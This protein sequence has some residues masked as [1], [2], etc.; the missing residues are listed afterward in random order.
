MRKYYISSGYFFKWERKCQCAYSRSRI[1]LK[2][3]H[4]ENLSPF[5]L[6]S[7]VLCLLEIINFNAIFTCYKIQIFLW[8][9]KAKG[10]TNPAQKAQW[11]E[12]YSFKFNS[13][14]VPSEL[15]RL[16]QNHWEAVSSSGLFSRLCSDRHCR[17]SCDPLRACQGKDVLI[18]YLWSLRLI[19]IDGLQC[20]FVVHLIKS[21]HPLK[22][23]GYLSNWVLFPHLFLSILANG[24]T[25]A[26]VCHVC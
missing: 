4:K 12:K 25:V 24:N 20:Y 14:A 21:S 1:S 19:F 9:A 7:L 2:G 17:L 23:G 22:C 16:P 11:W 8:V 13:I 15:S 10:E 5:F 18:N 26:H 3:Q 6:F